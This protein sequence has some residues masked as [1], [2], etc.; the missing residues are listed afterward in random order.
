MERWQE[1][2]ILAEWQVLLRALQRAVLSSEPHERELLL[3]HFT[4]AAPE[5]LSGTQR[6]SN[7]PRVA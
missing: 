3:S 2:L 1:Q 4:D 6:L 7:L 5:R